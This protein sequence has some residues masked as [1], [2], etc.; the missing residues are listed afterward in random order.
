MDGGTVFAR[1][2]DVHPETLSV[3]C[4][5]MSD[6]R[7]LMLV[8]V[9]GNLTGNTGTV[10]F[11]IPDL[12]DR[13]GAK[14]DKFSP[15]WEENKW[16]SR[17][18]GVRD[19]M[20]MIAFVEGRPVCVGFLPPPVNEFQFS[21]HERRL[22]R[23]ASDVYSWTD[24]FGNSQWCH[25]N[26]SHLSI[27][28]EAQVARRD[29]TGQDL[30]SKWKITKN[31]TKKI[32]VFFSLMTAAVRTVSFKIFDSGFVYL[33]AKK[34]IKLAAAPT[35]GQFGDDDAGNAEI[36]LS[37]DEK[38]IRLYGKKRIFL[39][40]DE[41]SSVEI[42][43]DGRAVNI[44]ASTEVNVTAPKTKVNGALDVLGVLT[45]RGGIVLGG[46]MSALDGGAVSIA[47]DL[48]SSGSIMDTTGN[49]NHHEHENNGNGTNQGA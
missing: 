34:Q 31:L 45:A 29:I 13:N 26:G 15:G 19:I 22:S 12:F 16:I 20:A 47:G 4:V 11:P 23:H 2:V 8:P 3:D 46:S 35:V 9:V 6:N 44:I 18:T 39:Y 49:S 10:D 37:T 14:L 28:G 24:H 1:V 30:N 42:A 33:T 7:R 41:G 36:E 38:S 40:T 5:V 21:E 27:G 32:N 48:T 17:K 43:S 25:P